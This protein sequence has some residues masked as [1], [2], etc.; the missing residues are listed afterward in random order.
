LLEH[1]ILQEKFSS[2]LTESFR[3]GV[4]EMC[5]Y[6]STVMEFI[7]TEHTPKN[8]LIKAIRDK[9]V[10]KNFNKKQEQCLGL[11]KFAGI[12]PMFYDLMKPYFKGGA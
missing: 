2:L 6:R 8:L 10:E 7:D 9:S 3:A 1:G 4:L 11:I 5:G 12:E